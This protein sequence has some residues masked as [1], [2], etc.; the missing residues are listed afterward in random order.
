MGVGSQKQP[1]GHVGVMT[2]SQLWEEQKRQ[3]NYE[4]S[5]VEK[6]RQLYGIDSCSVL[7]EEDEEEED[8]GFRMNSSKPSGIW[9]R[10]GDRSTIVGPNNELRTKHDIELSG[11]ANAQRLG[12][13]DG[14]GIDNFKSV[15]NKAFN[16]F[17][18]SMQKKTVKG[19]AAHGHGRAAQET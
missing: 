19:V 13:V 15:G 18:Q 14:G 10:G 17:R 16:S 11:Q 1:Q 3:S 5:V 9:L 7:E 12:L 8:Q 4:S 2:Q 6:Q